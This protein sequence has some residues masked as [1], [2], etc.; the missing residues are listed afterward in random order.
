L[1]EDVKLC[2]GGGQFQFQ[3]QV[4]VG[5]GAARIGGRDKFG[6]DGS[7]PSLAPQERLKFSIWEGDE[8]HSS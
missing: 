6:G 2:N 8:V 3:F 7:R 4:A 5:D 1:G